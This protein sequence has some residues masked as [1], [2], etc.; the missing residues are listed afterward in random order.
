ML[1]LVLFSVFA[2]EALVLLE[3][4]VDYT[5]VEIQPDM[6][7]VFYEV[8]NYGANGGLC[9]EIKRINCCC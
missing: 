7:D 2:L 1:L 9:S 4:K 3:V 8:I 6:N 5:L